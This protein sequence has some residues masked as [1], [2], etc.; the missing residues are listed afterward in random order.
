MDL[1]NIKDITSNLYVTFV[2]GEKRDGT[3][4]LILQSKLMI[5][6]PQLRA[7]KFKDK[8]LL[9]DLIVFNTFSF[10][11]ER[12]R[13]LARHPVILYNSTRQAKYKPNQEL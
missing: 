8:L 9:S 11:R 5:L 13:S 7:A 6:N 2:L 4:I 3:I 10:I 1:N 12:E